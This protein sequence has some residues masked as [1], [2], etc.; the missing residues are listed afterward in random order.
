MIPTGS[1][2]PET[3][4]KSA[5]PP[6]PTATAAT[7]YTNDTLTAA[8][9]TSPT[10]ATTT[11][12]ATTTP[13]T[14]TRRRHSHL[15]PWV[16][17]QSFLLATMIGDENYSVYELR[18]F[19]AEG[20]FHILSLKECQGFVFNQ[21][22]FALPYQQLRSLATERIRTL[23]YSGSCAPK[24]LPGRRGPQARRH[25]LYHERRPWLS[26]VAGDDTDAADDFG[27]DDDIDMRDRTGADDDSDEFDDDSDDDS[28]DGGFNDGRFR[29]DVTEVVVGEGDDVIG[30]LARRH[31]GAL[32]HR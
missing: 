7:A 13:A 27:K 5:K 8:T 25:T 16:R 12:T 15:T 23:S 32:L 6:E 28:D 21:D 18:S 10:A 29:V 20:N 26:D 11:A 9:T 19:F 1:E 22:L 3:W 17:R 2:V 14:P 30:E 4:G 31:A 24:A